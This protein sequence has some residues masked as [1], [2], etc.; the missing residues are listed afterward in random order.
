M[1]GGGG[2]G[3]REVTAVS[4]FLVFLHSHDSV[5]LQNYKAIDTFIKF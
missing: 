3:R 2:G 1:R 4:F 5:Q